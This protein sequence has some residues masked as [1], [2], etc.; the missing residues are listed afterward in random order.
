MVARLSHDDHMILKGQSMS[1]ASEASEAC[2]NWG[3]VHGM[4]CY[5]DRSKGSS[6]VWSELIHVARGVLNKVGEVNPT[7]GMRK[8]LHGT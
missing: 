5:R 6:Q 4:E 2:S 3:F 1:E 7:E 8:C